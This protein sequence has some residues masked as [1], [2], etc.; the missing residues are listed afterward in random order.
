M[1]LKRIKEHRVRSLAY[2][3]QTLPL[4]TV[5]AQHSTQVAW[6]WMTLYAVSCADLNDGSTLAEVSVQVTSSGSSGTNMSNH[7]V[8]LIWSQFATRPPIVASSICLHRLPMACL[9]RAHTDHGLGDSA[10]LDA[11]WSSK[12]NTGNAQPSQYDRYLVGISI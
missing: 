6:I 12:L 1:L 8:S 7:R 11:S 9:S 2:Q 10:S 3:Q 5:T 4:S